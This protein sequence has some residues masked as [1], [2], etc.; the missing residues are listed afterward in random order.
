MPKPAGGFLRAREVQACPLQPHVM[1]A[2]R[3]DVYLG[4]GQGQPFFSMG[5][6]DLSDSVAAAGVAS[7]AAS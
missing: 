5:A 6:S 7:F 4:S 2:V 1:A 3:R